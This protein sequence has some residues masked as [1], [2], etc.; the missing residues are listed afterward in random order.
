MLHGAHGAF[1]HEGDVERT[2]TSFARIWPQYFNFGR[3]EFT[4][5][6][7]RSLRL[8]MSDYNDMGRSH[9]MLIAHG[10]MARS[11]EL[12]GGTAVQVRIERAPW[13]GSG[14]LRATLA[15]H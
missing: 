2:L 11:V 4:S 3:L 14:D 6:G 1:L 13:L 9:G 5:D 7:P 8:H 15:W 10:W 12:A